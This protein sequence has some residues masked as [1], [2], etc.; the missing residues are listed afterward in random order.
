MTIAPA[1]TPATLE[2]PLDTPLPGAL[3]CTA[4]PSEFL[5]SLSSSYIP[6][7]FWKKRNLSM[8]K[9]HLLTVL[10]KCLHSNAT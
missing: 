2:L 8:S 6:S 7:S 5:Y 3:K 1:L 4:W 10:N 9:E